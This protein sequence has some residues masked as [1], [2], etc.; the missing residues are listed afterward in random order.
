MSILIVLTGW[1]SA[2]GVS[3]YVFNPLVGAADTAWNTLVGLMFIPFGAYSTVKVSTYFCNL[4]LKLIIQIN[5]IL[6]V[7]QILYW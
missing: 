1:W 3:E 7:I 4:G 6:L 2:C 5:F